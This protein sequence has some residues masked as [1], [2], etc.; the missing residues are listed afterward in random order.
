MDDRIPVGVLYKEREH[1]PY[2]VLGLA[3]PA[4]DGFLDHV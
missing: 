4:A 3:F 2:L 1:A